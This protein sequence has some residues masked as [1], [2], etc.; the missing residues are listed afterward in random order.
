MINKNIL[1][2]FG[3]VL[4]LIC[5]SGVSVSLAQ[6]ADSTVYSYRHQLDINNA[7]LEEIARLPVPH[8]L[9]ERIY[10]RIQRRGELNNIYE[11][12]DI[13]G[14]TPEIFLSLKPLI[15]VE[16]FSPK[17]EREERVENLY[18]ELER[19]EGNEGINQ[20]LVDLWIEQALDPKHI[21]TIR[22][23]EL[24]NLQGV[25][26]VDA[27]AIIKYRRQVG[28]IY[29]QRDLRSAPFLS[30]YGYRNANDFI[31]FEPAAKGRE[32]HGHLLMRMDNTPFLVEEAEATD[33]IPTERVGNNYPSTFTRFL[34]TYGSDIQFGYSYYH[35]LNEPVLQ[36][37]LGFMQFPKG[38][39]Y[40]GIHN[41][42]FGPLKLRKVYAGNYSLAFGQ[43]VVMENSDFFQPRKSGY[44]WRK[45]FI[46]LSGDNS[47]TRQYKLTGLAAEMSLSNFNLFLFGS[48]DKRDAILN[49]TPVLVNGEL[50]YPMNQFIVL[51]QRFEFAPNDSVRLN[52]D[53][54]WRNT[55]SELLYGSHFSYDFTPW[56]EIGATYYESAYDRLIRP[57]L[58]EVVETA[59]V[60]LADTEIYNAYGGE[61][62]DGENPFWGGAKSF[63]RVYGF[64][65]RTVYRNLA[66]Q[67]EYAELDKAQGFLGGN[68]H[69]VVFN[70]YLQYESFN[71]LALYR[72]YSLGFDNPY[73]RSFSNYR[74]YKRTIYE[75]YFYLQDPQYGQLYTNNP[76]PQAERGY[77]FSTRYQMARKFVLTL[78][79]DNWLRVSDNAKQYRAVGTIQ[80]RPIFPLR[81][82]FRQK[83]QGRAVQNNLNV[84]YF[85]NMEFR[86]RLRLRLSSYDELGVMYMNAITKFRPRPRFMFP[87]QSGEELQT[88]NLAGNIG[89]PA[90]ALGG[91]FTHN[92]SEM[93]KVK[94]FLGYYKGFF[95]N[96][97]DTQFQVMNSFRGAMRFWVSLYSRLT[98]QISMRFKYTRDFQHRLNF[99]EAR[100]SNN[101]P[102]A[103]TGRYYEARLLQP[104]QEFYYLEFNLHF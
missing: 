62:S 79:Y 63:R 68:P 70:A 85:E 78:E 84:D 37:D 22:Y 30:Y 73:Q 53:L 65:F 52:R 72:D 77:Y 39:A 1:Y 59:D 13:E 44:S 41:R 56:T 64:D 18:Y 9:A 95:W 17:T 19:W 80:F 28:Q 24:V 38:K 48:F 23:D 16:P 66:L 88:V 102:I 35:G 91:F 97:E 45:R 89:S 11:L 61:V 2:R 90:E 69:A 20:A 4:F 104:V 75:D 55:V 92:F 29:S 47:L 31:S 99:V 15:R 7:S 49:S 57:D 94:G 103:N 27:A 82:D 33:L 46:G 43:G 98:N 6:K 76:Q 87:I 36:Q 14:M 58:N 83:Y 32:F 100:E 71:F 54:P 10:E 8:S 67:G 5:I 40:L 51:D 26:P 25:S 3:T 60:G 50:H 93:L 34:G 101:V 12:N 74:R 42:D 21:N 86:G 96:F 81:F